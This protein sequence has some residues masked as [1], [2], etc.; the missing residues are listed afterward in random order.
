MYDDD[1]AIELTS[2]EEVRR[3][4]SANRARRGY[5]LP[6]QGLMALAMPDLQDAY[7][8]MYTALTLKRAHLSLYEKEF[9]WLGVLIAG[10]EHIGTHHVRLFLENGGDP[11]KLEI[12]LR[13]VALA[14]G[15]PRSFQF[16]EKY[17]EKHFDPLKG[18]QAYWDAAEALVT[19]SEVPLELARLCLLAIHTT[20]GR[21]WGIECE[22]QACYAIGVDEGKMGEVTCMPMWVA[23]MNRTIDAGEVWLE[24]IRS[25]KIKAGPSFTAWAEMD[26]G[27]MPL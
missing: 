2:P 3:R 26:Q 24:Q 1:P 25:G 8:V 27:A 10:G 20:L 4:L 19:G 22:L 13:L 23:G 11:R 18:R 12:I 7:M 21:K 6:H 9:V 16:L 17:W 15:A 5:L 14:D